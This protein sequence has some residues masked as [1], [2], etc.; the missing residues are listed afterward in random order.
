MKQIIR[1]AILMVAFVGMYAVSVPRATALDG[2]MIPT[3]PKL[4]GGMIPTHPKLDG[5]MIPT[6][7]K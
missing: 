5:G 2:G 7:P 3:H 1:I 4:D 6:H